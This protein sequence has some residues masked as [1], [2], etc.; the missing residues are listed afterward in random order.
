MVF[1][2][3][4]DIGGAQRFYADVKTRMT[5]LGRNPDHLKIP[6]WR[7]CRR[8]RQHRGSEGE[9]WAILD[10]LVHYD[11]A[12]ASLSITALGTDASKFDP[13]GPLPEIPETNASK[14][15]RE[16]TIEVAQREN[17]NVRQLAQ[18]LGGYSGL[19]FVGTPQTIAD[20]M[21]EWLETNA[22]DG[23]NIMF[24]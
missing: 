19:A 6:T 3:G 13:E 2:A 22:C 1:A 12:I 17:L 18:R 23:F 20:Q 9:T 4:S 15:G 14:T 16:R 5:K 8:R 10:S 11:S 21:Q 7:L 24:P